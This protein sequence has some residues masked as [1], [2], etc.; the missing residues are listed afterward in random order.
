MLPGNSWGG[1]FIDADKITADVHEVAGQGLGGVQDGIEGQIGSGGA[2]QGPGVGLQS[3]V[4]V[5][6]RR[7]DSVP[8]DSNDRK[9]KLEDDKTREPKRINLDMDDFDKKLDAFG[10][11]LI[12]KVEERINT[13]NH[14]QQVPNIPVVHSET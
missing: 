10:E 7:D 11:K 5:G 9:R 14:I 3:P 8:G 13:I 12:N 6:D 1:D 4:G 2:D